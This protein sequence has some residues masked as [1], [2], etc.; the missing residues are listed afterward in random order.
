MRQKPAPTTTT[1]CQNERCKIEF[2]HRVSK[3]RMYC[4]KRCQVA[5]PRKREKSEHKNLALS[6]NKINSEIKFNNYRIVGNRIIR[7]IDRLKNNNVW[8]GQT[9]PE[10]IS[11]TLPHQ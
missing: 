9:L 4:S 3:P 10:I 5:M 1:I 6:K 2:E 11:C 8:N 7:L